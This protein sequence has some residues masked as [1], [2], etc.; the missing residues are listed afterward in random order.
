[1]QAT[2]ANRALAVSLQNEEAQRLE[3]ERQTEIA[4]A[5]NAFL[6]DD[7]LAAAA[8]SSQP[9]RGREVSMRE[10]LEAAAQRIDEASQ[11]G[12]RFADK[13]MVEASIRYMIGRTLQTLGLPAIALPHLQRAD[14]LQQATPQAS[15]Q[16]RLRI[17]E[18]TA[19]V[20]NDLGRAEDAERMRSELITANEQV[21]GA[22]S[23]AAMVAINNLATSHIA[24]GRFKAAQALF[25]DAAYRRTRSLGEGHPKTLATQANLANSYIKLGKLDEASA[26]L[27]QV[28][29]LARESGDAEALSLILMN[30]CEACAA[31]QDLDAAERHATEAIELRTKLYGPDHPQ[32]VGTVGYL[33]ILASMQ[34]KWQEAYDNL[35]QV[36]GA[37]R[38]RM[39]PTGVQ[40][41][42]AKLNLSSAIVYLERFEEAERLLETDLDAAIE[43]LGHDNVWIRRTFEIINWLGD[44]YEEADRVE[45]ALRVR[46]RA[47]THL[48]ALAEHNPPLAADLHAAAIALGESPHEILRDHERA[49]KYARRAVMLE[50]KQTTGT[51]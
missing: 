20:F 36:Y 5:V 17:M 14:E 15:H 19:N 39:G 10:V 16:L 1:M 35:L 29:P 31:Q 46:T 24:H 43:A 40:T 41:V 44:A 33:G 49:L 7:L 48:V 23:E 42:S 47:L 13:P 27:Q 37:T 50:S 12:G 3:A 45:D 30:L 21:F 28:L 18:T 2:R 11:P 8:P 51:A 26:L 34:G 32:T 9:G 38:Q 25:Q 22:E 4:R 6:N